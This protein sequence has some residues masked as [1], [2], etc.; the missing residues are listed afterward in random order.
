M[1]Q[2]ADVLITFYLPFFTYYFHLVGK[3]INKFNNC[4]TNCSFGDP[5]ILISSVYPLSSDKMILECTY[6]YKWVESECMIVQ[7]CLNFYEVLRIV[8]GF[9]LISHRIELKRALLNRT[10]S[11]VWI[12]WFF[13]FFKLEIF[14]NNLR[15]KL[16][17]LLF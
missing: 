3:F 11:Q 5:V 13:I 2:Y 8:F 16:Y 12:A 17:L 4:M 7:A 15:N 1:I 6:N 14:E 9:G 10:M